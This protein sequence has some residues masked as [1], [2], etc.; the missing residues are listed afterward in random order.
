MPVVVDFR[1]RWRQLVYV[2]RGRVRGRF[3]VMLGVHIVTIVDEL[4][5]VDHV[6]IELNTWAWIALENPERCGGEG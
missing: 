3:V 5:N 6:D 1:L 2:M 4:R